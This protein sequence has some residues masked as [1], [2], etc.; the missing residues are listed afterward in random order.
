MP[1][2]N[3]ALNVI[4]NSSRMNGQKYWSCTEENYGVVSAWFLNYDGSVIATPKG[5]T[6]NVRAIRNF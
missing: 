6:A 5:T 2:I 1:E 4:P 3:V